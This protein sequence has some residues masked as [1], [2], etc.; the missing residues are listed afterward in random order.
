[1][2]LANVEDAFFWAQKKIYLIKQN[3]D[4]INML[5]EH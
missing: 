5:D 3:C 1:M 2:E 4:L